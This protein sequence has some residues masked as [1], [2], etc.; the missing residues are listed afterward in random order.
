M[1]MKKHF[2]WSCQGTTPCPGPFFA[3]RLPHRS[4]R[5]QSP[6]SPRSPRSI[7]SRLR[8]RLHSLRFFCPPPPPVAH[9]NLNS[10]RTKGLQRVYP[11]VHHCLSRC[12]QAIIIILLCTRTSSGCQ[13]TSWNPCFLSFFVLRCPGIATQV[14]P[15]S[16]CGF[17]MPSMGSSYGPER[18]G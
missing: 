7:G 8:R 10:W 16:Q 17:P 5:L 6:R 18:R 9:L 14:T 13:G 4:R 2:S 12:L 1:S 15:S 3:G 11:S